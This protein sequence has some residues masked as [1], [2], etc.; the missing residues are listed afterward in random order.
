MKLVRL[1]ALR[2]GRLY[3]QAI[4]LVL[5]SV[6]GWINPRAIVR[7]EIVSKKNSNGTI[8]NRTRDLPTCSA[9]PQPTAHEA[10][11]VKC[12]VW[13][14]SQWAVHTLQH[15]FSRDHYDDKCDVNAAMWTVQYE[16][17]LIT[18]RPGKEIPRTMLSIFCL[19]FVFPR[20]LLCVFVHNPLV[21][22]RVV[23]GSLPGQGRK[24]WTGWSMGSLL[25][26]DWI[27]RIGQLRRLRFT[28]TLYLARH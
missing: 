19:F 3:P 12:E 17:M 25:L 16:I 10:I 22:D 18:V 23:G 7:P 11:I 15:D 27:T 24:M 4:F 9:V 1:S 21:E 26:R 20:S 14:F 2:T 13:H 5:I 8:G 6:R 28:S